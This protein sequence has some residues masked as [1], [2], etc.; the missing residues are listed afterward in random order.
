[1]F[2]G[3]SCFHTTRLKSV[4]E[5][6][7]VPWVTI[8]FPDLIGP[9]PL[10]ACLLHLCAQLRIVDSLPSCSWC[11]KVSCGTQL[12][13]RASDRREERRGG[14]L[15]VSFPYFALKTTLGFRQ[16]DEFQPLREEE[17]SRRWV[18]E[19]NCFFLFSGFIMSSISYAVP[20]EDP[21]M[22]DLLGLTSVCCKE[23][24]V[25]CGF[26]VQSFC[27][28]INECLTSPSE[29]L[30]EKDRVFRLRRRSLLQRLKRPQNKDKWWAFLRLSSC[31]SSSGVFPHMSHSS[32]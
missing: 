32:P 20:M 30:S 12:P 22:W 27:E 17:D 29:K 10:L 7:G 13:I 15:V 14:R 31:T 28:R 3:R 11:Q 6:L 16:Q 25:D 4:V 8:T 23:S 9:S 5:L 26:V 19:D 2:V 24:S 18:V 1:M 21:P